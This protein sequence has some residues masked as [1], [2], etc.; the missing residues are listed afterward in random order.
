MQSKTPTQV[1]DKKGSSTNHYFFVVA[2]MIDAP[3]MI[4]ASIMDFSR[5]SKFSEFVLNAANYFL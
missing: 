3:M 2:P 4:D 5:N 1:V